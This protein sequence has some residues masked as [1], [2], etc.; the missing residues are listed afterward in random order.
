MFQQNLT[1]SLLGIANVFVDKIEN[2]SSS[3]QIS[4][5]TTPK[6]QVCPCC[7]QTTTYIFTITE[8]KRFGIYPFR[9]KKHFYCYVNAVTFVKPAE[10]D[11]LKSTT[12]CHNTDVLQVECMLPS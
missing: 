11:S 2:N 4:L 1:T 3:I 9:A 8:H 7:G 5:S 10:S 12:F 6:E